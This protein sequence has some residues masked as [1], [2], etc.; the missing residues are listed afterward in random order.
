[1]YYQLKED[2]KARTPEHLHLNI[3]SPAVHRGEAPHTHYNKTT[4]KDCVPGR[5]SASRLCAALWSLQSAAQ[6]P[7]SL[8]NLS[9]TDTS[10]YNSSM[11]IH[12]DS[13]NI[14]SLCTYE[15][16]QPEW[17]NMWLHKIQKWQIV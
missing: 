15:H 1:M 6:W 5:G 17:E 9:T 16:K 10:T 8:N 2:I 13:S 12:S 7:A 11:H 4:L 14:V 3:I